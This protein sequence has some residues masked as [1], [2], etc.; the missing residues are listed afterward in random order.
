MLLFYQDD[1]VLF[2]IIPSSQPQ[3]FPTAEIASKIRRV[4]T[5][6]LIEKHVAVEIGP[7]SFGIA[8]DNYEDAN[9]LHVSLLSLVTDLTPSAL[10]YAVSRH[11][12]QSDS[13]Y[14]YCY[15]SCIHRV[16]AIATVNLED[17]AN[18]ST[19]ARVGMSINALRRLDETI[20]YEVE[21]LSLSR[22]EIQRYVIHFL[23]N[24]LQA[25]A[26]MNFMA[27]R[28]QVLVDLR[29][30]YRFN[31]HKAAKSADYHNEGWTP[32]LGL[33]MNEAVQCAFAN[34]E[35]TRFV[36][37]LGGRKSLLITSFSGMAASILLLSL[38]FTWK[39]RGDHHCNVCSI[40]NSAHGTNPASAARCGM[41]IVSV[42]TDAMGNINMEDSRKATETNKDNLSALMVTYLSTHGIYE[43]GIDEI[44][45]IIHDSGGQ[46]YRDG[47]NVN[48]QGGGGPG[49]RPIGVKKHLAPFLPSHTML[50]SLSF[51]WKL[52][53]EKEKLHRDQ[54]EQ[55]KALVDS[56]NILGA[57]GTVKRTD[58]GELSVCVS[59]FAL[60]TKSLLP[61]PDK[62]HG[63]TDVA[64]R[65]RQ[66]YVDM[67][68]NPE[69]AAVFRKR[70]KIDLEI[71][72]TVESLGF[73][74]IKLRV[75]VEPPV[76]REGHL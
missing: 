22:M 57:C 16:S 46:V 47:V 7:Q 13:C 2:R 63:L 67:I 60:L 30:P 37:A 31:R 26:P 8:R 23:A 61:L 70:A 59:S 49:M 12:T 68:A 51:T 48:A 62:Y 76:E 66:R 14:C 4:V 15:S 64:K 29:D 18:S 6:Q 28:D 33:E 25:I 74:E 36:L 40:P 69:V 75:Y 35:T 50:L 45:E 1:A 55:L 5:L 11:V 17:M 53:C 20:A 19:H 73:V 43:E 10:H 9:E 38:S 42:G 39:A 54:F 21:G 44:C 41:K 27:V 32:A 71:C 34:P 58:K 72:K 24:M 3:T 56:G 65:Y 52:Y